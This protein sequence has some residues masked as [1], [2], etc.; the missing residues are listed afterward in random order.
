MLIQMPR[1][2]N[3]TESVWLGV[4]NGPIPPIGTRFDVHKHLFDGGTYLTLEVTGHAWSLEEGV[5]DPDKQE[6]SLPSFSVRVL[7]KRIPD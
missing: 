7:T 5:C 3:P 2:E 6:K 1:P 4:E